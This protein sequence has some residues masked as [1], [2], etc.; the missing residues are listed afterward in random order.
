MDTVFKPIQ[1]EWNQRLQHINLL[2]P[3]LFLKSSVAYVYQFKVSSNVDQPFYYPEYLMGV[4]ILSLIWRGIR[5][6]V[7]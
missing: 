7:S 5:A 6:I 2:E 1:P 4:S 3:T